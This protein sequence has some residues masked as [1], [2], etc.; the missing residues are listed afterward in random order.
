[1]EILIQWKV[2]LGICGL[3]VWWVSAV[4]VYKKGIQIKC[5]TIC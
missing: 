2:F 1:M 5:V 3:P 4:E